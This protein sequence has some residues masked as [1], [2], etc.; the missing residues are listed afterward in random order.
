[1]KFRSYVK[2]CRRG[3]LLTSVSIAAL[4]FAGGLI[5]TA[6]SAQAG[7]VSGTG[8]L[9]GDS[10]DTI[11]NIVVSG[12]KVDATQI[13]PSRPSLDQ[14]EPTA[15]INRQFIE[16]T[17]PRTG[18]FST[19]VGLTP[20][21]VSS[22][23]T[24]GPGL[25]DGGKV[26]LRGFSDGSYNVTYD[27]IPWGDTNGPSHHGTAFFP[28]AVIGSV[29]V[30][31]GPGSATS[32]GQANF[33]GSINLNSIGL[34]DELGG[35]QVLT[36]GPW[37]TFE[38]VTNLQSGRIDSLN[39]A[40]FAATFQEL[41]SK[42]YLS[43]N[44]THG[45]TQFVKGEIPITDRLTLT[46]LF[47]HTNNFY[48]KSD[49][50]DASVAQT[51]L[52]GRNFSLSAD[53]TLQNYF[54]YNTVKKNTNF[55]YLK[56][57]G[58]IIDGLSVDE[59]LYRYQYFNSTLSGQNN[60]AAAAAN[61]VTPAPG[62]TYPNPGSSYSSSL[63]TAGIPGY[64]KANNYYVLGDI[65][66]LTKSFGFGDLTVGAMWE[67]AN[68]YR[69]IFDINLVNGAPDYREKASTLAGPSG[70]Y[71]NVPL[72]IQYNE[73]SGWTQYQTFAQFEWK[74]LE[75]LTVTPGV[76][77]VSFDLNV[78]AP[79]VKL[80][81]GTQP[82]YAD[83]VYT[84]ALPFLTANYRI[85]DPWSVYAQYAQ[86][87]LVPKIG[88][89]YVTDLKSTRVKPQQST[90]YQLGTVYN[91]DR[92]SFDADV[93]YINFTNKL[94]SFTDAFGQ[95][96]NTNSGG[97][98]YKGAE[99]E[100][101]F[102]LSEGA[103]VFG[104]WSR[105]IATGKNDLSNPL[106]N[107]RQLTGVPLWSA[108]WGL[109]FQRDH[110][111]V[112]NDSLIATLTD[113]WVGHSTVNNAKCS[114]VISGVCQAGSTL[115]PVLGFIPS[116]D[117]VDLSVTYRLGNYSVQVQALNL[118]D[119]NALVSAKG[120]AYVNGGYFAQTSAQGGAANALLYQTPRTIEVSLKARF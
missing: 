34:T 115:T 68:T 91:K 93:Y 64:Q 74:P 103:S 4:T 86:G 33:G 107:G 94:Q 62:A 14:T 31:R 21:V 41:T 98:S 105:T 51:E 80:S 83:Q 116:Y 66:K 69:Y 13:A 95:V 100:G 55:E 111:L 10:Q 38:A 88:N 27:G 99:I 57:A 29:L 118:L 75:N 23:S 46:A 71:A 60:L 110:L 59:T 39:G 56:V 7:V 117:Q 81:T 47:T 11:D 2:N 6:P 18:D 89:L 92:I 112:D 20:S 53:P 3:I 65:A 73:W 32:L 102:V 8:D 84:K 77:Y 90:N 5:G 50:G 36:G 28:S 101:A 42:G 40:K 12:K 58:D 113:K 85:D 30:D 72:N 109:R 87:F 24:N 104:N 26:T 49:I 82:V 63:R 15:L 79:E 19:I 52:Y 16:E 120:T 43:N 22:G 17:A 70:A 67:R 96:Y 35:S 48:N 37:N 61:F 45:A 78:S 108:A 25:S 44:G 76:K 54:D 1:M 97:A 106:Y 119:S 114:N 9:P